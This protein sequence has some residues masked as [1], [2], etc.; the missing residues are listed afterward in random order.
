MSEFYPEG[1]PTLGNT[2]VTAVV[3][4]ANLDAPDLSSEIG[5]ITSVDLS[6]YLFPAGWNPTGTT[7]K[8][9]KPD[10]LCTKTKQEQLNRTTYTLP[11]LQYTYDPQ[12]DDSDPGNEAK[13]LLVEGS[14]I[15]LVE[16]RGL[17]ATETAWAATQKSRVHYVQLG[18]QIPMGDPTD[19]NAEYYLMQELVYV[20]EGPVDG[21]VSA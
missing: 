16:R 8:G 5:A 10:R 7:A 1:T 18:P 19:E 20:N 14:K 12:G 6:C 13:E 9:S 3:S 21:A 4:V 2:K 17:D 11:A 15:F